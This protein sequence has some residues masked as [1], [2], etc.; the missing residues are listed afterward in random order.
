MPARRS[1]FSSLLPPPDYIVRPAVGINISDH[2]MKMVELLSDKQSFVLGDY[3][4]V[5]L[6]PGAVQGGKINDIQVVVD[7]LKQLKETFGLTWIRASIPEEEGYIFSLSLPH[8]TDKSIESALEFKITDNVPLSLSES[9]YDYSIISRE[10]DTVN[11][12]VTVLPRETVETHQSLYESAGLIPL[13]FEIE[14]QTTARSVI[15]HTSSETLA[16]VDIGRTRTGVAIVEK[17]LVRHTSTVANGGDSLVQVIA[18]G[19]TIS[20]QE[21]EV[22]KEKVGIIPYEFDIM[23]AERLSS[24]VASLA[25]DVYMQ[26]DYWNNQ[27]SKNVVSSKLVSGVVLCGGNA[28]VPGL[29]EA[30]AGH[31][32]LPVTI[33]NV[34]SNVLSLNEHIPPIDFNHSL[35]YASA[36][37]LALIG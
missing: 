29:R 11:V 3:D 22:V 25:S 24:V 10:G 33:G 27:M 32:G 23:T 15:P 1:R 2:S 26:I 21:A 36:I 7:A 30:L 14:A 16:I 35:G 18:Q 20:P 31:I 28:T 12:N 5:A 13:S 17:Q 8:V 9:V 4:T 6:A 19:R 34:W 37:G